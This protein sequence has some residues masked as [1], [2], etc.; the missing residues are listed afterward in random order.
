MIARIVLKNWLRFRGEHDLK[1]EAKAYAIV[2]QKEGEEERSNW[3]G[4]TGFVEAVPF[5]LWGHHR[6][7][8]DDDWITDGEDEGAVRLEFDIVVVERSKERGKPTKLHVRVDGFGEAKGDEAQKLIDEHVGLSYEDF[9]RGPYVEQKKTSWF[10]LAKPAERIRLAAQWF[11]FAPVQEGEKILR[12]R[13]RAAAEEIDRLRVKAS[14]HHRALSAAAEPFGLV[15]L[16]EAD[17]TSASA[18]RVGEATAELEV[19]EAELKVEEAKRDRALA[20]RSGARDLERY[21]ELVMGGQL[22]KAQVDAMDPEVELSGQAEKLKR[23]RDES[24]GKERTAFQEVRQFE[25][26]SLGKFDGRCPIAGRQCPVAGEINAD[27]T[28][29]S[30]KLRE[31][32]EAYA[33][34]KQEADRDDEA[35]RAANAK[36]RKRDDE[37]KR[38]EAMRAEARRLKPIA[39]KAAED[40]AGPAYD[41]ALVEAVSSAKV[42]VTAAREKLW[43]AQQLSKAIAAHASTA[44]AILEEVKAKEKAFTTVREAL[45]IWGRNGAQRRIAEK[46]LR[47]IQDGA[48]GMLSDCGIGLRQE[49][50]WAHEGKGLAESCED[51]GVPFGRS[52]KVKDCGSCGAKRGPNVEHALKLKLSDRSGA[53][54]D[55]CGISFQMS[56]ARWVRAD[57]KAGWDTAFIDEPFGSL[58]PANSRAVASH[59]ASML[60]ARYGF[61][62]AFVITHRPETNDAFPGRIE[63]VG[64]PRYS[65]VRVVS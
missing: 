48:N 22:L 1:L 40:G 29:S 53:A 18:A 30:S 62:Q 41:E 23:K 47:Q 3:Q 42:K 5:C 28:T 43:Q 16:S 17:L 34:A 60:S 31:A 38:L 51:C 57:R 32:Q 21:E 9:V 4:K 46:N 44:K 20:A 45:A 49:V 54:E 37:V 50:S 35:M 6:H 63:V 12:E 59:V 10:V 58:D 39:K 65:T 11:R 61:R 64:G 27:R 7:E 2:A 55:L 36:L 19:A 25:S 13:S 26:V 56:A 52:A 33:A 15:G 8:Y 24:L 14:E